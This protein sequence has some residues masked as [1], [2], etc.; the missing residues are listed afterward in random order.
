MGDGKSEFSEVLTK[1][2]PLEGVDSHWHPIQQL[3]E[4][5]SARK[6]CALA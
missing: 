4:L 3:Q 2:S 6:S 5:A 1:L